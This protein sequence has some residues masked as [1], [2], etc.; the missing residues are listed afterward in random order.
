MSAFVEDETED[1]E[2]DY[3]DYGTT[4]D[5]QHPHT[6]LGYFYLQQKQTVIKQYT[7]QRRQH[8]KPSFCHRRLWPQCHAHVVFPAPLSLPAL[9]DLQ[10][11]HS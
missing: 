3:D 6:Q 2:E 8:V 1:E 11:Y 4:Y 9:T 5:H 7:V 10:R